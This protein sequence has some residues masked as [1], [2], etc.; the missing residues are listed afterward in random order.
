MI[1]LFGA[2]SLGQ[3]ALQTQQQGIEVAGRNLANVHNP[4]YARQRL[5]VQSLAAASDSV[6]SLGGGVDV[7]TISHVRDQFLDRHLQVEAGVTG[8]LKARQQA[9]EYAQ[10][11]LGQTIARPAEGAEDAAAAAGQT[12]LA[13]ALADL[14]DAFQGLSAKPGDATERFQLLQ[15]AQ[16]LA[17]RFRQ[18]DQ[19]LEALRVSLDD[20]L[21]DGV[22]AA[23]QLLQAIAQLNRE[24]AL[25]EGGGQT[26]ANDLRDARQAKLEALGELVKVDAVARDDGAVDIALGG[27]SFVVGGELRN[28][29]ETYDPGDARRL[30]RGRDGEI[31]LTLTGGRLLGTLT[32]RDEDVRTL[33]ASL[34]QLAG[35]LISEV[36]AVHR[37][38]FGLDGTTGA[39]FFTGSGAGDMQVNSA[40]VADPVKVQAAGAAGARGDN[41]VALALAQLASKGLTALGGMTFSQDYDRLVAEVGE[42]LAGVKAQMADQQPLT[43]MLQ[44]RREAVGGVSLDEEMTELVKYQRAYQASAR[45]ISTIDQMFDEVMSLKR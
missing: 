37:G 15:K 28:T 11:S 27:V 13:A 25:A 1:G 14:F 42:T 6:S 10:A 2:L 33:R 21:S 35:L 39:E 31:P 38:G 45:L 30:L 34:D 24:I 44:R 40:L 29:F 43:E 9:L 41:R 7:A 5:Q 12:G 18:T 36:N 32:A 26:T 23:N 3:R 16:D 17:G 8:F 20:G 19:R 4:A 22:T